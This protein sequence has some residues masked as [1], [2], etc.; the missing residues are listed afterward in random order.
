MQLRKQTIW[1]L[2]ISQAPK[3]GSFIVADMGFYTREGEW[4][5]WIEVV[6]YSER[7]E[8]WFNDQIGYRESEIRAWHPTIAPLPKEELKND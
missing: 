2:D 1:N 6:Q 4:I 8:E 5:E 7:Y 3:D